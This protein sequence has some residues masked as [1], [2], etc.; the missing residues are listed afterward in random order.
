[1]DVDEPTSLRYQ[2]FWE[3]T[4]RECK[5][6]ETL[7][8][9]YRKMLESRISAGATGKLPGCETPHAKT[10]A[11][12]YDMEGRAR[13]MRWAI[14]VNWQTRKWSNF[15][16]SQALA[17]D[18][19]HLK[20]EEL[21]SVGELSEVCSQ[22]VLRCLYSARIGRHDIL[23]SVNK[24]ARSVTKMDSGMWQTISKA[25]FL[26]SSHKRIPTIL[27]CGEHNTAL[28]TVFVSRLRLCWRSWGLKINLREKSYV[29]VWK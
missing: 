29:F 26:H 24:L 25:D 20:Q 28:Q 27:S 23:R 6:N 1:M 8:D 13:K 5:P 22:I 3:C 17:W 14:L 9:E 12:S 19:H 2:V 7:I 15:T 16:K 10:V 4:R 11:W 21:E 18:D